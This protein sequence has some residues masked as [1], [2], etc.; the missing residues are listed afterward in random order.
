D[1]DGLATEAKA[2]EVKFVRR[3]VGTKDGETFRIQPVRPIDELRQLAL[4]AKPPEE[5]GDFHKTELVEPAKLDSS[6]KLDIRYATT[7]NFA[8]SVF[9]KQPRAF[10]QKP[11]AESLARLNKRLEE[12]G[13]GLLIYDAYR[14]W[15]VTKMFW[16]ATPE[17]LRAFVANPANGSRHNRGCA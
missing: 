16:E 13:L 14:P 6:I 17:D 8:D 15:H 12:R 9:Y 11:A 10:L 4:A 3:K 2:A 1:A 5:K 7:N